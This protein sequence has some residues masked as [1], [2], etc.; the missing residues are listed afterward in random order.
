MEIFN[1]QVGAVII[2]L[3]IAVAILRAIATD[4]TEPGETWHYAWYLA[5]WICVVVESLTLWCVAG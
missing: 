5:V 1:E 3:L 2:A 4:N